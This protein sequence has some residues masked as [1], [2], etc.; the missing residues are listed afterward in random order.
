MAGEAW[1][2]WG[3][4]RKLRAHA[5]L[6]LHK[7]AERAKWKQKEMINFQASSTP[8][9][10]SDTLPQGK[11]HSLKVPRPSSPVHKLGLTVP[12]QRHEVSVGKVSDMLEG[13]PLRKARLTLRKANLMCAKEAGRTIIP[14]MT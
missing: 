8:D 12:M 2:A 14:V 3:Q 9:T 6:H 5:H 7:G 10:H 1:M 4:R 11:L 13:P